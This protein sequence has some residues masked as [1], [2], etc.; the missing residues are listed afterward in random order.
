MKAILPT[1]RLLPMTI[2]GLGVVLTLKCVAVIVAA[3]GIEPLRTEFARVAALTA[4]TV[5]MSVI[6]TA[7]A[8][9]HEAQPAEGAKAAPP[10]TNEARPSAR[11]APAP[12]NVS[13]TRRSEIDT[14]ERALAQREI[15]LAVAEKRLND[16][17]EEL[18]SL[19]T[20]LKALD[21]G[22]KERD[23]ANWSGLVKMYEGMRPRDAAGI[24]NALDKDVLL[25]I[26]DRMKPAKAA[27]LLAS[28][29]AEKARQL[30]A[31][32]ATKRTRSTITN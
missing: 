24:F 26:L 3:P 22:L 5:D 14:R 17:I 32:L 28:M 1:R 31:D 27:P 18:V 15:T 29:E 21:A 30:T 25:E 13:N 12:L 10:V 23:A 16:R 8:A 4:N 9:N 2:A 7:Q 19:Q 20:R 6:A 11:P